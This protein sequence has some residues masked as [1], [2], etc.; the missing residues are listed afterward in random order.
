[1]N[2]DASA[3]I[4]LLVL[5]SALV[6]LAEIG[7]TYAGGT[8][9]IRVDGSIE[10]TIEIQRDG[11]VYTFTGDISDSLVVERDNIVVDGAGHVLEGAGVGRGIFLDGRSN[12]TIKNITIREFDF[13]I[14]L[15][16]SSGNTISANA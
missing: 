12:V 7:I 8:I 2:R 13:G 5:C 6:L 4:L 3:F 15:W 14:D 9:Y 16:N 10:G 1:M 11:N